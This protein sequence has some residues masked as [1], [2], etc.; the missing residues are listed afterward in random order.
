MDVFSYFSFAVLYFEKAEAMMPGWSFERRAS[1]QE[2]VDRPET[3]PALF[4]EAC[5]GRE[6]TL[7][8]SNSDEEAVYVL[9]NEQEGQ[10]YKTLYGKWQKNFE[11]LKG[12]LNGEK[13]K[14][15]MEHYF[16]ELSSDFEGCEKMID[17][18]EP[19]FASLES[20]LKQADV[21]L[22]R[23]SAIW[24]KKGTSFDAGEMVERAQ[25]ASKCGL[26]APFSAL[27]FIDAR[28]NYFNGWNQPG[29]VCYTRDVSE[30]EPVYMD[31]SGHRQPSFPLM[32]MSRHR[33]PSCPLSPM[34]TTMPKDQYTLSNEH[35]FM[36]SKPAKMDLFQSKGV[37]STDETRTSNKPAQKK[38]REK[39]KSKKERSVE[40]P[41]LEEETT[42]P[43]LRTKSDSSLFKGKGS[44]PSYSSRNTEYPYRKKSQSTQTDWESLNGGKKYFFIKSLNCHLKFYNADDC[45]KNYDHSTIDSSTEDSCFRS[46]ESVAERT[47]NTLSSLEE[48]IIWERSK[49]SFSSESEGKESPTESKPREPNTKK[50]SSFKDKQAHLR[51]TVKRKCSNVST[52]FKKSTIFKRSLSSSST[53]NA[54]LKE[55]D[56]VFESLEESK[57]TTKE[58]K[59]FII[60]NVSTIRQIL[61]ED[62]ASCTGSALLKDEEEEIYTGIYDYHDW[63]KR[64]M[65]F[66]NVNISLSSGQLQKLR[67][68]HFIMYMH[69]NSLRFIVTENM[70]FIINRSD[71]SLSIRIS[72]CREVLTFFVEKNGMTIFS[73]K[74]SFLTKFSRTSTEN[75]MKIAIKS[76]LQYLIDIFE[77]N[78]SSFRDLYRINR[79][80]GLQLNRFDQIGNDMK[81]FMQKN[82]SCFSLTSQHRSY[83]E[84]ITKV[85][86]YILNYLIFENNIG[87]W[88]DSE[89]TK[90]LLRILTT[91]LS[92]INIIKTKENIEVG[93]NHLLLEL[94]LDSQHLALNHCQSF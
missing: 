12:L 65:T 19:F 35:A 7:L 44:C 22:G 60:A 32:D 2:L 57:T 21:F 16:K 42:M 76:L 78:S 77:E 41:D 18:G 11:K 86:V 23:T 69:P 25:Q 80:C 14:L 87:D 6:T 62:Q 5:T 43:R 47:E 54:T 72:I 20:F 10:Q 63:V 49:L 39:K 61:K 51:D 52:S 36:S 82:F 66:V 17:I 24:N 53:E 90:S 3:D 71:H 81:C 70:A 94:L 64:A 73:L 56:S 28:L 15:R 40:N 33:Q 68:K 31:M 93:H 74:Q 79:G 75:V 91:T 13:L 9:S 8:D 84:L 48:P 29:R 38:Y 89:Q 1:G 88:A 27:S 85:S 26:S 58:T 34:L 37:S 4:I 67:K 46:S 83:F 92:L 50:S 30:M 45:G 59:C 55:E